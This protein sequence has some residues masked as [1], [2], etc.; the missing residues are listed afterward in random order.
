[1]KDKKMRQ[2]GVRD[3]LRTKRILPLLVV[4]LTLT[5]LTLPIGNVKQAHAVNNYPPGTDSDLVF[6]DTEAHLDNINKTIVIERTISAD[7]TYVDWRVIWNPAHERWS[8]P[9]YMML[10]L[11]DVSYVDYGT[12]AQGQN[13]YL[14][15]D[16][17]RRKLDSGNDW[18]KAQPWGDYKLHQFN[19]TSE[20][21]RLFMNGESTLYN[22]DFW[23]TYQD[24]I[25]GPLGEGAGSPLVKMVEESGYPLFLLCDYLSGSKAVEYTFRTK[26]A[27]KNLPNSNEKVQP[28]DIFVGAGW[29]QFAQTPRH[30]HY[31]LFTIVG[32]IDKDGD[33]TPDYKDR[34]ETPE[35]G[36]QVDKNRFFIPLIKGA[37]L[38]SVK[39]FDLNSKHGIQSTWFTTVGATDAKNN[40]PSI[41]A[42][43][44]EYFSG[45]VTAGPGIEKRNLKVLSNGTWTEIKSSGAT[46][47]EVITIPIIE[48]TTTEL[49]L[50]A[51][52][53]PANDED[54]KKEI[55]RHVDLNVGSLANKEYILNP[56][57][58][59][60]RDG[61][62]KVVG[63]LPT[64]GTT[65]VPV[66]IQTTAGINKPVSHT[67][68]RKAST[69]F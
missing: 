33:G 10:M 59:I 5:C 8:T 43:S 31:P 67:V 15:F 63:D 3:K 42:D 35:W 27:D 29:Y 68:Y 22:G 13:D 28:E 12:N 54:F 55:L 69:R 46:A 49:D 39:L 50:T 58:H 9:G 18:S 23:K 52:G 20:S 60:I 57:N 24:Y 56:A 2:G 53:K 65:Q 25:K 40:I 47:P 48:A 64:H 26:V 30:G 4:A 19:T 62:F 14:N 37:E 38:N 45:T 17:H 32:P 11:P 66:E 1:M 7:R 44:S 16:I 6:A 34:P 21:R 61:G 36:D 51:G 41:S